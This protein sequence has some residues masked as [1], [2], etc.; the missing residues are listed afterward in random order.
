M[1]NVGA[2]MK[3][4]MLILK[5]QSLLV[6]KEEERGRRMSKNQGMP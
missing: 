4:K 2:G 3:D 6:L 1:T 5:E